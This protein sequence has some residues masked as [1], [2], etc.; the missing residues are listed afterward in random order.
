[1]T[2]NYAYIGYGLLAISEIL[3]LIPQ[4]P[5]NGIIHT[6][7]ISAGAIGR[8]FTKTPPA[9]TAQAL[10]EIACDIP[11]IAAASRT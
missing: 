11:E 6:I 5:Q 3:P 8:S 2:P 7:V 9:T 1:M 4:L 10:E